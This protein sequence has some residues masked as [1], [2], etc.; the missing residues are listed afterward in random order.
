MSFRDFLANGGWPFLTLAV[1][2]P[3]ALLM[4][5]SPLAIVSNVWK[6]VVWRNLPRRDGR[7]D[8]RGYRQG[9]SRTN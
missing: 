4:W 7:Y 8:Q 3:I 1:P 6:L 2:S 5:D 9:R